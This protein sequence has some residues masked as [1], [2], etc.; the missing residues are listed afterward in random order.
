MT[1]R[2]GSA[3]ARTDV[4]AV[5]FGLSSL[6]PPGQPGSLSMTWHESIGAAIGASIDNEIARGP[7]RCDWCGKILVFFAGRK[8]CRRICFV[9]ALATGDTVVEEFCSHDCMHAYDYA[10]LQLLGDEGELECR[11]ELIAAVLFDP[12]RTPA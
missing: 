3:T 2:T 12:S 7:R 10:L 1:A 11:G 4:A 5:S 6:G 8:P 9:P